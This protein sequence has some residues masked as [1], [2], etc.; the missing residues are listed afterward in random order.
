[1]PREFTKK[2]IKVP[3]EDAEWF[4]EFYPQY[5]AWTWFVQAALSHF[6]DLHEIKAD[7]IIADAVKDL[8]QI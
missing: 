8:R 2:L 7:D 1:M 4:E 5:G 3:A 6:R